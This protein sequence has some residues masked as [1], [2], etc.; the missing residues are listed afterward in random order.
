MGRIVPSALLSVSL[1]NP[2]PADYWPEQKKRCISWGLP[3]NKIQHVRVPGAFELPLAAKALAQ[4]Q[5]VDASHL[6]RSGYSW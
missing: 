1:M 3:P 2:S 4:S 5:Q 6:F